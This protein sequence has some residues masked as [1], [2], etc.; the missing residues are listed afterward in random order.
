MRSVQLDQRAADSEVKADGCLFLSDLMVVLNQ[1]LNH[2][3]HSLMTSKEQGSAV[4]S[5]LDSVISDA[6]KLER[7]VQELLD[8]VEFTK[9]SDI[10]GEETD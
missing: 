9:N 10:R 7:T 8:Q 1:M 5:K 3:E 4:S 6:H 2:T